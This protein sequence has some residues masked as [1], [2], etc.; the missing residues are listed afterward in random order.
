MRKK[1]NII[2]PNLPVEF[3]YNLPIIEF[4]GNS[5]RWSRARQAF[6]AIMMIL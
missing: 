6:Y 5:A 1:R 2:K 4:T 3:H